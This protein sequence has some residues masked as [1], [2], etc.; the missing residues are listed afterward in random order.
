MGREIATKRHRKDVVPLCGYFSSPS[1]ANLRDLGDRD[2][3][4]PAPWKILLANLT[5]ELD[6]GSHRLLSW[7]DD[8]LSVVANRFSI[9]VG[10]SHLHFGSAERFVRNVFQI[11]R[12][13]IDLLAGEILAGC[14][15]EVGQLNTALNRSGISELGHRKGGRLFRIRDEN[16]GDK[17]RH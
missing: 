5:A 14:D 12:N 8:F 17:Q 3:V 9:E 16:P 1:V 7:L 10:E 4:V 11:R 13:D 6:A 15:T 2:P